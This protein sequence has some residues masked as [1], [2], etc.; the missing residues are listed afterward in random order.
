[1]YCTVI[2][3]N[4]IQPMRGRKKKLKITGQGIYVGVRERQGCGSAFISCGSGSTVF[5]HADPDPA[6]FSMRIQFKKLRCSFPDPQPWQK[7]N[8][9]TF[10]SPGRS[11]MVRLRTAW[12]KNLS[13]MGSGQTPLLLPAIR[14]VSRSISRRTSSQSVY[15]YNSKQRELG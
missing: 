1:M 9:I 7:V 4:E 15:T 8:I 12:E 11:T 10:V 13:D 5:F 3:V 6:A 2:T 14:S